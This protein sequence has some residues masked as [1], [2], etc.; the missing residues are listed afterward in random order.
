M[1]G[2]TYITFLRTRMHT[3]YIHIHTQMIDTNS[4]STN[5]ICQEVT[6]RN[7]LTYTN[8]GLATVALGLVTVTLMVCNVKH[9]H[10]IMKD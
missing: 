2:A 5:G 10:C 7:W 8:T 3:H 1:R 4:L 6:P 9:T